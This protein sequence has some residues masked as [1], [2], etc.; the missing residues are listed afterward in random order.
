MQT[1]ISEYCPHCGAEVEWRSGLFSRNTVGPEKEICPHCKAAY[2]TGRKEWARMSGAERREYYRR[3]ALRGL[4]AFAFWFMGVMLAAFMVTGAMF[5]PMGPKA[6][7]VSLVIGI[8]G[9]L[10]LAARIIQMARHTIN[11]SVEREPLRQ[12]RTG[13]SA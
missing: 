5:S 1:F 3:T 13:T 2:V 6:M 11:T 12:P 8:S 9:G 7:L 4:A 10:A